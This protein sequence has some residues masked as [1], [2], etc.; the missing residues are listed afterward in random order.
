MWN[1]CCL[2]AV[3]LDSGSQKVVIFLP[4]GEEYISSTGCPIKRVTPEIWC[5]PQLFHQDTNTNQGILAWK[6]T[7]FVPFLFTNSISIDIWGS[8]KH[9]L[10]WVRE[11]FSEKNV[12][13][14]WVFSKSPWPPPPHFW[15][16]RG[17]FFSWSYF[18]FFF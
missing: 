5:P 9:L 16:F 4:K 15:N 14:I 8:P 6:A 11:V 17:T 12:A 7:I 13:Q 10:K 1:T 18:K 2:Q 3:F